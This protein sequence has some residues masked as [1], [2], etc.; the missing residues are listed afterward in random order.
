MNEDFAATGPGVR[1]RWL[2]TRYGQLAVPD[3]DDLIGR[4]LERFGEWAWLEAVFVASLLPE[5]ARVLDGG[6]FVG[7]F[8]LGVAQLRP[9][10]FLCCIEANSVVISA[11]KSNIKARTACPT[12]VLEALLGD[13]ATH[14]RRGHAQA[15]NIGSTSFAGPDDPDAAVATGV[16]TLAD[17]RVA[18]GAFDLIKLDIEGMELEVLRGDAVHLA[19]GR[20]ALWLE[21]N[22]DFRTLE[23]AQLLRSWGLD[24]F[25]FAFPAFNPNNFNGNSRPVYPFAF[26]AGLLAAPQTP[27]SLTA[28]LRDAGCILRRIRN[29]DDLKD[30][31]WRTPRWGMAE[32]QNASGM[33]EVVALAGRTLMDEAFASFLTPD[34][35]LPAGSRRPLWQQRDE[36][37]SALRAERQLVGEVQSALRDAQTMAV[38]RLYQLQE[39]E[40]TRARIEA[41]LQSATTLATERLHRLNAE[42]T[43]REQSEEALREAIAVAGKRL[44]DL[45]SAELELDAIRHSTSWRITAPIRRFMDRWPTLR[46]LLRGG[47]GRAPDLG[48]RPAG[49]A[50]LRSEVAA[51]LDPATRRAAQ[52]YFDATFYLSANPDVQTAGSDPLEHFLRTGWQEGRSPGPGFDAAYYIATYPDIRAAGISPLLHYLQRGRLEGRDSRPILSEERAHLNAT[53]APRSQVAAWSAIADQSTPLSYTTLAVLLSPER[54]TTPMCVSV[55]HDD[56]VVSTGGVQNVIASEQQYFMSSGWRYLHVSPAA[57]LPVLADH[58]PAE[59]YHLRLRLDGRR[60]GV[61]RFSDLAAILS[62]ARGGGARVR[63]VVHQLLG[64]IPELLATFAMDDDEPMIVW[65]HDFFTMCASF[66]LM[67]NDVKFCGCPPVGSGA[68]TI[69]VFG[70]ERQDHTIRVRGFFD[71]LRPVVL[72]PSDVALDFWRR[73]SGLSHRS[74]AV[75]PPA[76]LRM[77]ADRLPTSNDTPLRVAHL[78]IA[79]MRK[80]WTVFER[81]AMTCAG[82]T[83]YEFLHLGLA[84]RPSSWYNHHPVKVTPDQPNAMIEAVVQHNIDV[85]LCWSLWPE[86][87][88][89]TAYEALAG[90]AYVIARRGAGN[91]WPAVQ[92]NAPGQG[93]VLDDEAE[94]FRLFESGEVRRLVTGAVRCRGAL[95]P[96]GNTAEYLLDDFGADSVLLHSAVEVQH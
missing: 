96:G 45:R 18:Y 48:A 89:F 5:G 86:T 40:R 22:E 78:G 50:S 71:T 9:L 92:A 60:I 68:C 79:A 66:T 19:Q 34:N 56:Y 91:V 3:G 26:E 13:P 31:L 95:Y 58:R 62:N 88:C 16:A 12:M 42:R 54:G 77:E 44:E 4:F 17:L 64:H 30:A 55:S 39:E 11:L 85:V 8:G 67:R 70:T 6:A 75:L 51:A 37:Q 80:G 57:P 32:W 72:A 33:Q 73:G 1:L 10:G 84:S 43:R 35:G 28:E 2:A 87:F 36:A 65:L 38:E 25:Y 46:A 90:G 69:C 49:M 29:T 74:A 61:A 24:L 23:V 21:A 81:L 53:V 52:H 41:S 14:A 20:T 93:H 47:S 7:T 27:P 15:G 59:D 94:L 83:R 63:F 76:R 82:D